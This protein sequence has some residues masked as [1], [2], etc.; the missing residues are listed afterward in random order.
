MTSQVQSTPDLDSLPPTASPVP[1]TT[2]PTPGVPPANVRAGRP[3]H[4]KRRR[5][6]RGGPLWSLPDELSPTWRWVLAVVVVVQLGVIAFSGVF[7]AFKLPYFSPI[8]ESAHFAYIQQLAQHGSLPVLGKTENTPQVVAIQQGIYPRMADVS[9]VLGLDKLSYEAFQPPL[10]YLTA[11]PAFLLTANYVDKIYAVRL[12]DVLLLLAAV[13]LAGRL[14]R[15]VLR[16]RWII[17]WSVVLVSF[18][19]P[20]VVVRFVC[21]SNL[22]LAVPM[23]IL[24]TTELWIAWDRHSVRRLGVAGLVLG[25]CVLTELEL[26]LFIPLFA[27]VVVAEGRRRWAARTWKGLLVAVAVPLVV[28]APWFAFNEA[29]YHMTTA[30]PIAI[31]EQTPIVNPHHLHYSLNQLPN[32]TVELVQVTLPSEW[33]LGLTDQVGLSYLNQLLTFLVVPASL[34][35]IASLG[36]RLWSVRSAI[37]GLPWVLNMAELWYIR[38]GQQWQVDPRYTYATV[39]ILLTLVALST[40]SIRARFL[41]VLVTAG[42]TVAVLFIWGYFFISYTGPFAFR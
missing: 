2:V 28:M 42:S 15:V 7:G 9:K 22:A 26:I 11:V 8:D 24:F 25:L 37:L 17:G 21:I 29:T 38:Y 27:L 34:V 13:A 5:A 10:Y 12:F 40:D 6:E 18:T 3:L 36:R 30:G 32:D 39:P 33:A 19:L 16:Q 41:P 20:G 4:R 31:Q 1:S 35:M 23:A 14:C